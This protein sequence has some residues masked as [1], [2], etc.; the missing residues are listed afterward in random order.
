MMTLINKTV[1]ISGAGI[2]GPA[3]AYWLKQYGFHPTVIERVSKPHEG[4]YIFHLHGKNGIEVL[5]RT[6]VWEKILEKRRVDKETLFVDESDAIVAKIETPSATGTVEPSGAQYTLKRADVARVLYDHTKDDVEYLFGDSITDI[7]EDASGVT[8]SF[9]KG[10]DQRFDLVIGADG[11]HSQVRAIAFGEEARFRHYL[12]YYVTGYT[13][14][15]YPLD[16]GVDLVYLSPG[17]LVT[18]VGLENNAAIAILIF[19]Q[20]QELMYDFRDTEAQKKLL[21]E[22]FAGE[23]WKIPELLARM[24]EVPDFF[25]DSVSQIRMDTWHKG[26]IALIG[27]AGYC[28]TLLSGFGA[29]LGLSGAYI[30]AGEL[31][32]AAGDYQK[33]FEAY[34]HELRPYVAQKQANP[35]HSASF[36]PGSAFRLR[37]NHLLLRLASMPFVS[38]LLIRGLYGGLLHETFL[39]K[40]YEH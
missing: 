9:E 19:R 23:K 29:Q 7:G 28:P 20:P 12:G 32:A 11:L 8:V 2:A 35:S 38:T 31:M 21:R 3:L 25:F 17:K 1:L 30:L 33:A 10:G 39:L 22:A 18:L 5:K 24:E 15:N 16:Y 26:R 6:G 27:D 36:I 40:S 13:M 4:G 37:V 14:Q 34:E